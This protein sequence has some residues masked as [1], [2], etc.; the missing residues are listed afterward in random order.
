[1]GTRAVYTFLDDRGTHHVYKRW[2]GYPEGA[3]QF[4]SFAKDKAWPLPRYEADEF[5]TAFISANKEASGDLRL[6]EHWDKHGDLDYRYEVRCRSN[7]KD[8]HVIIY[9]VGFGSEN[10]KVMD[11]GYLCDLMKKYVKK[12]A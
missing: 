1:M 8:L 6:T 2:D 10:S 9:Q 3:L 12:R 5:A 7:D 4:I 11:Q